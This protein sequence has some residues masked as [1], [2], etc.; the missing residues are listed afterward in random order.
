MRIKNLPCV[1]F[2]IA[3]RSTDVAIDDEWLSGRRQATTL[4]RMLICHY[5][6]PMPNKLDALSHPL[7]IVLITIQHLQHKLYVYRHSTSSTQVVRVL[8]HNFFL[9]SIVACVY[10][11]TIPLA[12][13]A[14]SHILFR[15]SSSR[16]HHCRVPIVV[17]T[18][19][20]CTPNL[21]VV[22]RYRS[23]INPS[24]LLHCLCT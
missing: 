11:V 18:Q 14:L 1:E 16:T 21:R 5:L 13:A 24:Q 4:A 2:R 6:M 20:P 19:S 15:S 17:I 22:H 7:I 8:H 12:P 23:S 10:T 3:T 9:R